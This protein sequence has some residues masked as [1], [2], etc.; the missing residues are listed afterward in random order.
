[1]GQN[2]MVFAMADCENTN[3]VMGPFYFNDLQT[4]TASG[5]WAYNSSSA[6]FTN[7]PYRIATINNNANFKAYGPA[8]G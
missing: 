6:F 7:S 1:M 2:Q 4:K 3:I 5:G 8:V